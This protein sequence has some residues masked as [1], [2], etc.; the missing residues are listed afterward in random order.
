M[1]PRRKP[2]GEVPMYRSGSAKAKQVG[3]ASTVS[4]LQ[5]VAKRK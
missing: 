1:G 2:S 4:P 3:S 5:T